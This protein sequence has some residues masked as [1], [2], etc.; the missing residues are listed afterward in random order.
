MGSS[1][2]SRMVKLSLSKADPP[3]DNSPPSSSLV[4]PP[5][6]EPAPADSV[7]DD[8]RSLISEEPRALQVIVLGPTG[9]PRED[10]VTSLLVKSLATDWTPNSMVAVDAGTLLVG[11]IKILRQSK[12]K[13]E[14]NDE[15]GSKNED[16]I[17]KSG[18]FA[19]LLLPGVRDETNAAYIFRR[20][21]GSVLITHPHLDHVAG[22]A[23]N[24][25]VLEAGYEPKPLAALPSVVDALKTHVFNQI[26]WPNL[27]DEDGGVG[28]ITYKR[29]TEGGNPVMGAGDEKGYV[30][31]CEGLLVLAY[32]VSHG[33]GP[34]SMETEADSF[35]RRASNVFFPG[36][37]NRPSVGSASGTPSAPRSPYPSREISHSV[38]ESS[39]FFLRDQQTKAE[40]LVFGDVEPDSISQEPRNR[41]VWEI[42]AS[43]I[44]SRRLRAI[45]IECSYSNA[46]EDVSLF[47]HLCP[48]HLIE[49]LTVLGQIVAKAK[50]VNL[51]ILPSTIAK[52]KREPSSDADAEPPISPKSKRAST[53]DKGKGRGVATPS[54]SSRA[55]SK[56]ISD[57]VGESSDSVPLAKLR[58][59]SSAQHVPTISKT[60]AW[61]KDLSDDAGDTSGSGLKETIRRRPS[62]QHVA[63]SFRAVNEKPLIGLS[64]FVIHVKEDMSDSPDPRETILVELK[65]LEQQAGLGCDF[66]FPK[67]GESIFL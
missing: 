39:A 58:H 65:E 36:D 28:L 67:R 17:V 49:E 66:N 54:Q 48:R 13:G 56:G 15:G 29:L 30:Q 53:S 63:A 46:T 8:R 51:P 18:P 40:I 55:L 9:G 26:I 19:G 1:K 16:N 61:E 25:P 27:S 64:I 59:R 45:F 50:G 24:T 62:A 42:A 21:I 12:S 2:K 7:D 4:P 20:I 10:R 35:I 43:K 11:I 44:V 52:R 22:F 6:N 38:T 23:I 33:H 47:G 5:E 60:R 32:G 34:P 37:I 41:K 14:A 31:A 3:E 57:G